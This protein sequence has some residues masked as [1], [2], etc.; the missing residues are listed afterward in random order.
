[1]IDVL[2]CQDWFIK[3]AIPV[4]I[5]HVWTGKISFV[6]VPETVAALKEIA[7]SISIDIVTPIYTCENMSQQ[8]HPKIDYS[9][10]LVCSIS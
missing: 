10:T 7:F 1:M 6:R 9:T 3:I 8:D 5:G 2:V 4:R